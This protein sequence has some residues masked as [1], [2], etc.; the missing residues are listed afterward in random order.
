MLFESV[1]MRRIEASQHYSL[2]R[3]QLESL[4]FSPPGSEALRP[5]DRRKS[6][7][8]RLLSAPTSSLPQ[9][10]FRF[11]GVRIAVSG[12]HLANH[13]ENFTDAVSQTQ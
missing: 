2:A 6:G 4:Q 9:P 1:V 12:E 3:L 11:E 8:R 5:P 10:P 13:P 7:L